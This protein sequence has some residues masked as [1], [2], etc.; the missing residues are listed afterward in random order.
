MSPIL[1]LHGILYESAHPLTDEA[2]LLAIT[3]S[4]E[5][6]TLCLVVKA[7]EAPR[8]VETKYGATDY[9]KVIFTGES[10]TLSVSAHAYNRNADKVCAFLEKGAR[11]L[12]K[13][14]AEE[15]D[16]DLF[17]SDIGFSLKL[18]TSTRIT[19]AGLVPLAEA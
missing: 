16:K 17:S 12:I 8:R 13:A 6:I 9:V 4:S 1:G 11:V 10:P 2:T 14:K 7:I 19:C 18:N 15:P 3:P 5:V